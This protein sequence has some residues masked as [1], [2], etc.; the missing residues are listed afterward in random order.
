[1]PYIKHKDLPSSI[2]EKLK[3]TE[4]KTEEIVGKENYKKVLESA[5]MRYKN[6]KS[7]PE[8]RKLA[9][10]KSRKSTAKKEGIPFTI[11]FEEIEYPTHCPLT[12]IKLNYIDGNK[13]YDSPS[14]DRLIP[15]LGYI[16]GNVKIISGLAN[17][18][19]GLASKEECLQFAKNIKKYFN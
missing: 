8:Y 7:N 10:F 3:N 13:A 16:K 5:N 15:E 9:N 17:R 19:K 14:I 1:M 18:M 11:L 2:S 4:G 12:G 6:N